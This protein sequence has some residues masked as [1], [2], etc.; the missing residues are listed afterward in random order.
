[1]YY[2]SHWEPTTPEELEKA[3]KEL[4]GKRKGKKN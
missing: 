3:K 1:M 4:K 2:D